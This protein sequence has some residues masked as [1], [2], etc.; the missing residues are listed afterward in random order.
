MREIRSEKIKE[1]FLDTAAEEAYLFCSMRRDFPQWL[2]PYDDAV[3][4]LMFAMDPRDWPYWKRNFDIGMMPC[5]M[6]FR[7]G[8]HVD[9]I[10]KGKST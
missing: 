2:I 5:L 4:D 6:V 10:R 3:G 8:E 9:T 7:D 1:M